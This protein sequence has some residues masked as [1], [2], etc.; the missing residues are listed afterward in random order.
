LR[1]TIA[2]FLPTVYSM[3]TMTEATSPTDRRIDDLRS[4]MHQ[5]FERVDSDVRELR[6]AISSLQR[7]MIAFFATTLGSV[8]AGVAVTVITSHS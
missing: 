5:G 4:E 3:D 1:T 8:L 7:L 2:D 6:S